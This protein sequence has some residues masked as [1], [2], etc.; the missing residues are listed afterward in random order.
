VSKKEAFG[1]VDHESGGRANQRARRSARLGR[2][3]IAV[4]L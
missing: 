4:P 1:E 2:L 3:R